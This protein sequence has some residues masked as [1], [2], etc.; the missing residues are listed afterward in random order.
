M[1]IQ[2]FWSR[3]LS[4]WPSPGTKPGTCS[5]GESG[6]FS[7]RVANGLA[8]MGTGPSRRPTIIESR[9]AWHSAVTASTGPPNW[10]RASTTGSPPSV[11]RLHRA[12]SPPT[13]AVMIT[14]SKNE[15]S[16]PAQNAENVYRHGIAVEVCW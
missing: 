1:V 10:R 7:A 2:G 6:N 8:P 16:C 11:R 4:P 5:M 9:N 14:Q 12:S 15:P 13:T 3:S